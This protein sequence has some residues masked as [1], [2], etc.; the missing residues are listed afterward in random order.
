MPTAQEIIAVLGLQP[1]PIEGG[2][3]RET[4]RS[5]GTIPAGSLPPGYHD[6][7]DRSIG[8]AIYYLLTPDTFPRCPA[9]DRR[10]LPLL[11][12]LAGADAPDFSGRQRS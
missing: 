2:F 7:R 6:G 9:A 4:Y 11:P 5:S 1:H 8:T 12:G 3:F 10:G